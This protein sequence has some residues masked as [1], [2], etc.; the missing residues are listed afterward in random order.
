MLFAMACILAVAMAREPALGNDPLVLLLVSLPAFLGG[1]AEDLT[2]RVRVLSR[3][4]LAMISGVAAYYFLGAT[5][6]RLDIFGVDWLLQFGVVS[7][8]CTTI[9]IAGGS[10]CYQYNRWV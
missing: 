1:L 7:L 5:L 6:T 2:K 3:L 9:A 8:V 4:I 10:Q